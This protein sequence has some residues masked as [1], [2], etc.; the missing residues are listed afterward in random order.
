MFKR[1]GGSKSGVF[2]NADVLSSQGK[3]EGKKEE[4]GWGWGKKGMKG[5]L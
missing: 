5:S 3:K 4:G 2:N 1:G